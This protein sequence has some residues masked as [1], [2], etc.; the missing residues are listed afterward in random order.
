MLRGD[1]KVTTINLVIIRSTDPIMLPAIPVFGVHMFSPGPLGV[2]I[3]IAL[4]AIV[5]I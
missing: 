4:L 1:K 2:E 3:L 5:V